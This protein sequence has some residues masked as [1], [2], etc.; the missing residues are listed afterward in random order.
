MQLDLIHSRD[1][2]ARGIAE[3]LFKMPDLKIGHADVPNPACVQQFLHLLPEE[4]V[5]GEFLTFGSMK[6]SHQVLMKSQSDR[7]FEAS[8]GSVEQGKCTR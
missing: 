1:N 4:L 7:C 8:S 2:L 5:N 6:I 3:Q